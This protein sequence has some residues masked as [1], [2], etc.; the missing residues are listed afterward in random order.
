MLNR[1]R[2]RQNANDSERSETMKL[3]TK[4]AQLF[5]GLMWQLQSYVNEQH[6]ILPDVESVEDYLDL[7]SADRIQVRDFLWAHPELID[8]Y[9][10]E[11]P[12]GLEGEEIT[13]VRKWKRFVTG[14]FQ[15]FR[16]L[17]KHAIFIRDDG[18]VY[19]VL[20]L[21]DSLEEVLYGRRLP[22]MAK[23]VL[24]PFKGR[25]VY[26]GML[27]FYNIHFGGG[28]RRG[29]NEEYM[30]AKQNDRIITTL[31]P[32]LTQPTR[33]KRKPGR[34]W[35]PVVDGLVEATTELKGGP[36]PAACQ[37]PTDPGG[38]PRPRRLE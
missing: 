10:T 28:I 22:V 2:K 32:E 1:H 25:I 9:V 19:G 24:M 4:D 20:A 7:P 21:R 27:S 15:I 31:E 17:K 33:K 13:I 29:L 18:Q 3:S 12:Y 26:D 6:Q 14:T 8:A 37:R 36:Q 34:D 35:G 5:Y 11:N 23:A 16:Y 38:R 30:A